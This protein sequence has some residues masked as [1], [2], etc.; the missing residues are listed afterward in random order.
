MQ[1]RAS[2][3]DAAALTGRRDE[4]GGGANPREGQ[5]LGRGGADRQSQEWESG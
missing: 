1:M 5:S 3:E 2:R 4:D